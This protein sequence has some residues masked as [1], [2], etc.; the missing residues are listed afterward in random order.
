MS[1][2]AHSDEVLRSALVYFE[3]DNVLSFEHPIRFDLTAT[4]MAEPGTVRSVKWKEA[5]KPLKL[6]PTAGVFGPT[7]AGKS[8]LLEALWNMRRFVVYSL[9]WDDLRSGFDLPFPGRQPFAAGQDRPSS[10]ETGMVIDGIYHRYGFTVDDRQVISEWAY[11]YPHGRAALIYERD[12]QDYKFGRRYHAAGEPLAECIG[13]KLLFLSLLG[14]GTSPVFSSMFKWFN[15]GIVRVGPEHDPDWVK[16]AI[17][18]TVDPATRDRMMHLLRGADLGIADIEHPPPVTKPNKPCPHASCHGLTVCLFEIDLVHG[19]RGDTFPIPLDRAST[20]TMRWWGLAGALVDILNQGSVVLAD[21]LDTGLDHSLAG[22][23]IRMF[24]D[25]T[26]NRRGSQMVFTS[27]S[28]SLYQ[29]D[30]PDRGRLLGRDQVW[31]VEKSPDGATRL[32]GLHG[33]SPRK[34]E[35]V[36]KRYQQGCYGARP[37]IMSGWLDLGAEPSDDQAEFRVA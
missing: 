20:G 34:H 16:A 4:R 15:G 36:G 24:N 17:N 31:L 3:A 14:R 10:Y 9:E 1:N 2:G 30:N 8:N 19:A 28:P 12:R 26:V 11:R 18:K 7:A 33:H 25:P 5:G 6:L 22:E 35:P 13:P 32:E 29:H 27:N 37:I 21:D 23:V